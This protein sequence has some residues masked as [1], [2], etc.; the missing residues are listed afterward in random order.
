MKQTNKN[1][2]LIVM[3]MLIA[4]LPLA[5]AEDA[6]SM[7]FVPADETGNCGET[8]TIDL[9]I[10]TND[11]ETGIQAQ[12]NFDPAC[13][14]ITDVD[15][16]GSPWQPLTPPGWDN[17]GD[18]VMLA[19]LNMSGVPAGVHKMATLTVDCVGCDC[20]SDIEI[21]NIMPDGYTLYNTTFNCILAEIPDVA[22]ISIGDGTG[23]VT[24]PIVVSNATNVGACQVTMRYD[25]L[26]VNV[27]NVTEGAMESCEINVENVDDGYIIVGGYQGGS[28]SGINGTFT[29]ANVEFEPNSSM[30]SCPLT[31]EVTTFADATNQTVPIVYTVSN[32]TYTSMLNGDVND[33]GYVDMHDVMLIAKYSVGLKEFQDINMVAADVTGDGK[34]DLTDAM[35][36]AKN[37]LGCSGFETLR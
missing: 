2:L 8:T 17:Y 31:I 34:V 7:Y 26:V 37:I 27:T 16:T 20:V 18:N 5:L 13:V 25:P 6:P 28:C 35:Y 29:L 21:T 4:T 22:E 24:I 15:F 19:S 36:L 3:M 9:M 33:D 12:I 30:S 1:I 11:T 10:N 14:N 23:V 32:G